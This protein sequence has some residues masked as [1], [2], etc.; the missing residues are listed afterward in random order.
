MTVFQV[1]GEF[2]YISSRNTARHIQWGFTVIKFYLYSHYPEC[3]VKHD[4]SR[5]VTNFF[6]IFRKSVNVQLNQDIDHILSSSMFISINFRKMQF[7][8]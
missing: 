7:S 2:M 4:C 8:R 1:L 5:R 6:D 3:S